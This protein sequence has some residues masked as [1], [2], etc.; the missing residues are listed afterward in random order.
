MIH[1]VLDDILALQTWNKSFMPPANRGKIQA[2]E[3]NSVYSRK[4]LYFIRASWSTKAASNDNE[5]IKSIQAEQIISS[6]LLRSF[7]SLC[8]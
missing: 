1:M 7:H 3:T 4:G 8:A 2:C 6:L 5:T